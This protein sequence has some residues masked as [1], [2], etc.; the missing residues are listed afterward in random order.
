[1]TIMEAAPIIKQT[2]TSRQI[3]EHYGF[4]LNRGGYICCPFHGEKT[5]SLKVHKSGWYCY[6]CH[7]GGD[8]IEFVRLFERCRFNQAVAKV[9]LYFGLDLIKPEKVSLSDLYRQRSEQKA[10]RDAENALIA[11]KS[12]FSARL[13]EDWCS[14]WSLYKEAWSAPAGERNAQQWWNLAIAEDMLEYIDYMQE[15]TAQADSSDALADLMARYEKGVHRHA[16]SRFAGDRSKTNIQAHDRDI[17]DA[18]G[19]HVRWNHP[20]EQTIQQ[21][22]TA[23]RRQVGA[24]G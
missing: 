18:A 1:M 7:E 17:P 24:L 2:V 22:G 5:P 21:A 16:D 6:G 3:V 11:E 4:H 15:K 19:R 9:D 13:D 12:A 23:D 10:K 20:P 8:A 14:N